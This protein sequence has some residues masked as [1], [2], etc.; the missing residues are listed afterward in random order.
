MCLP[1]PLLGS[2]GEEIEGS[3]T[4]QSHSH[5]GTEVPCGPRPQQWAWQLGPGQGALQ[6]RLGD[7][8]KCPAAQC[9]TG[10]VALAWDLS[11]L[12][13][14]VGGYVG[15]AAWSPSAPVA[16]SLQPPKDDAAIVGAVRLFSVL[17]AAVTMDL[18]GRKVLLFVS[19]ELLR[20]PPAAPGR[21]LAQAE[22]TV[23]RSS[24]VGVWSCHTYSVGPA[25][26]QCP[27]RGPART[28]HPRKVCR[29]QGSKQWV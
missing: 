6:P 19:G 29:A 15:W 23:A 2:E 22:G 21:W 7:R 4:V 11:A 24:G 20:P 3:A 26:R 27:A 18:A 8:R 14:L 5:C 28:S 13:P 10:A 9:S 17:I 25:P 12:R 1:R 16:S